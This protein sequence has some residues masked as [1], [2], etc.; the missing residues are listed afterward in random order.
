[1]SMN[2]EPTI[3]LAARFPRSLVDA[4]DKFIAAHAEPGANFT[5]S[6]A[7]RVLVNRALDALAELQSKTTPK[8]RIQ[9]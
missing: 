2:T 6:D 4:I 9:P 5:R 7:L 1:M 3:Y 8:R